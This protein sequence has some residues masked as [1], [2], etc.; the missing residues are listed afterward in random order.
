[1]HAR[2]QIVSAVQLADVFASARGLCRSITTAPDPFFL[3]EPCCAS[4]R[5]SQLGTVHRRVSCR[6]LRTASPCS[7]A[8]ES[9][10]VTNICSCKSPYSPGRFPHVQGT[11]CGAPSL[12]AQPASSSQQACAGRF[13][14]ATLP[15]QTSLNQTL[16][17]QQ[18]HMP[19]EEPSKQPASAVGQSPRRGGPGAFISRAPAP[20]ASHGWPMYRT[21]APCHVNTFHKVKHRHRSHSDVIQY[22]C[23]VPVPSSAG[24][25]G[26]HG[27]H[28]CTTK[29]IS[30]E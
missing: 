26:P 10:S 19:S 18:Y 21:N 11:Q 13:H 29:V 4:S 6:A 27:C 7:N 28:F 2:A 23:E 25:F 5:R 30:M 14:A 12:A 1:V 16:N 20:S 22:M 9:M 3:P 15:P 24:P 17:K 8:H